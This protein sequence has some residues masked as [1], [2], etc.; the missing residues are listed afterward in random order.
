MSDEASLK[1]LLT[2]LLRLALSSD[3][4]AESMVALLKLRGKL[5]R[6]G[7]SSAEVSVEIVRAIPGVP[8]RGVVREEPSAKRPKTTRDLAME[9]A[10]EHY[11][12]SFGT[13]RGKTFKQLW[14]ENPHYIKW[15]HTEGVRRDKDNDLWE[16]VE[17]FLN[18]YPERVVFKNR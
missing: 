10:A 1:P 17:Y 9:V 14:E 5:Q 2:K 6:S 15:I 13:H 18:R 16:L 3:S 4:D 11:K 7:Y 8:L 12:F